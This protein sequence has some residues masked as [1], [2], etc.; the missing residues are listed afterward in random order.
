LF[1]FLIKANH[2]GVKDESPRA[3]TS[4]SLIYFVA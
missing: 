2:H 4:R 3:A 1:L